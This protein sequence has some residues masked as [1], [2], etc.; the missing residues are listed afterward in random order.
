[1]RLPS[2]ASS[3]AP[4]TAPHDVCPRDDIARDAD[5]EDVANSL[6]EDYL[7][8][9]AR[10][11]ARED[12]RKRILTVRSRWHP[13]LPV[14]APHILLDEASITLLQLLRCRGRPQRGPA[15]PP[16]ERPE[17]SHRRTPTQA[18]RA[19]QRAAVKD[20]ELD[21]HYEREFLKKGVA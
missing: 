9:I 17:R 12:C 14:A 19:S 8:R 1:M 13:G 10:V 3:I 16:S 2:F 7:D 11:Q 4:F 20:R 18:D 5:P 15:I 21:C 6:I